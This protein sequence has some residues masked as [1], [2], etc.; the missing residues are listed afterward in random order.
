M[1]PEHLAFLLRYKL[2]AARAEADLHAMSESRYSTKIVFE[3]AAYALPRCLAESPFLQ[4]PGRSQIPLTFPDGPPAC[5]TCHIQGHAA[6]RCPRR[7]PPP[8]LRPCPT[9]EQFGHFGLKCPSLRQAAPFLETER[10]PS[11]SVAHAAAADRT[12]QDSKKR[13]RES[14]TADTPQTSEPL[15]DD[16]AVEAGVI[17][18]DPVPPDGGSMDSSAVDPPNGSINLEDSVSDG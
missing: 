7:P 9:C 12:T 6:A 2:L 3:L 5:T 13:A 11:A 15:S 14:G 18:L 8:A 4:P 17:T 1:D 10:S 16:M